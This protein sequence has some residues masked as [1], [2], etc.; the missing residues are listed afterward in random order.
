M[1][2]FQELTDRAHSSTCCDP[3]ACAR[4]GADACAGTCTPTNAGARANPDTCAC[5]TPIDADVHRN[6]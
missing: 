6:V 1:R 5:P 2:R 4:P 3:D